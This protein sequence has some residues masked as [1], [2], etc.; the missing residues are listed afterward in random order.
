MLQGGGEDILAVWWETSDV[1]K[2]EG[3]TQARLRDRQK[4]DPEETE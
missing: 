3:V 1:R 4:A 2:T